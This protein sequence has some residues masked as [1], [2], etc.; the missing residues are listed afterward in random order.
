MLPTAPP[1]APRSADRPRETRACS[2]ARYATAI[3]LAA[4]AF[5]CKAAFSSAPAPQTTPHHATERVKPVTLT[6][7]ETEAAPTQQASKGQTIFCYRVRL[8]PYSVQVH[9]CVVAGDDPAYSLLDEVRAARWLAA[10]LANPQP[11]TKRL[12]DLEQ[13]YGCIAW[14]ALIAAFHAA[15]P[16]P[17]E[18]IDVLDKKWVLAMEVEERDLQQLLPLVT[19]EDPEANDRTLLQMQNMTWVRDP[20]SPRLPL[21]AN[22]IAALAASTELPLLDAVSLGITLHVPAHAAARPT[23]EAHLLLGSLL[24]VIARLWA[25]GQLN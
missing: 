11:V 1:Q 12:D 16:L 9:Y 4:A 13:R 25:D 7:F 24:P 10:K 15:Q 20:Q 23:R 8:V 5:G 18:V 17:R 6:V 19:I 21:Q 3:L 22:Q 2:I 14:L